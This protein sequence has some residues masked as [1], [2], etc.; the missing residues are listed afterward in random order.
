ME[1]I[2]QKTLLEV[3]EIGFTPK[4]FNFLGLESV[5]MLGEALRAKDKHRLGIITNIG[6]SITDLR[7]GDVVCFN[8]FNTKDS[9]F[10]GLRLIDKTNILGKFQ[11]V[12][13]T[14]KGYMIESEKFS[15]EP[16]DDRIVVK[17]IKEEKSL[18]LIIPE[19]LSDKPYRV[20]EVIQT[21]DNTK[22]LV[23]KQKVILGKISGMPLI[24]KEGEFLLVRE[25][26]VYGILK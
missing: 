13:T 2:L 16:L 17:E 19:G 12:E 23:P 15:F 11:G 1:Y 7:V 14:E 8:S 18:G 6:E 9:L 10:S 3:R 20:A 22:K 5:W 26:E 25:T 24:L 21:G 4:S